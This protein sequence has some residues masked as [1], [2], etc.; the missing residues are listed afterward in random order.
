MSANIESYDQVKNL[1]AGYQQMSQE[2]GGVPIFVGVD[3]EGGIVSRIAKV[4]LWK[5]R[6]MIPCRRSDRLETA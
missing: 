3:E 2:T 5:H 4:E 6:Y 1:I